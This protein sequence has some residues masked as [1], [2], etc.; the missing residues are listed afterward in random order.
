MSR[1]EWTR[2]LLARGEAHCHRITR[3]LHAAQSRFQTIE[4]VETAGYGIG[5]FI[6]GRIQHVAADEYIYSEAIVH[7]MAVQLGARCRRALVVGGGPGGAV[8]ELLRHKAI[9][10]VIQV[11]IDPEMVEITRRYFQHISEGSWNDPRVRLVIAD[12]R[13]FL[14]RTDERFDLIVYDVSEPLDD[15]P[16]SNLF[17]ETMLAPLGRHLTEAG[18]FV[19]WAGSVGPRSGD[20]AAAIARSVAAV[21]PHTMRYLCHTQSYGTS[22]LTVASSAWPYDPLRT[23]PEEIDRAIAEHI[24]RPLKL[25]DGVTHV[26]MFHLPKDVRALLDGQPGEDGRADIRLRLHD[27]AV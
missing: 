7:P 13:D 5:L 9:R 17:A 19:T 23:T 3:R 10:S 25:Y 18:I 12:V 20:L 24:D 27:G 11:E 6:D 14:A 21:S 4:V 15:A 22:W 16:A 1:G 8:R 26:H 2:E